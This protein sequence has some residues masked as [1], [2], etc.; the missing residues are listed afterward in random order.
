[1]SKQYYPGT[2][3]GDVLFESDEVLSGD[4]REKNWI[5]EEKAEGSKSSKVA[6]KCSKSKPSSQSFLV[7]IGVVTW[8][9]RLKCLL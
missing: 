6:V 4:E 8:D 7:G 2:V 3:E 9:V 1:M 5:S